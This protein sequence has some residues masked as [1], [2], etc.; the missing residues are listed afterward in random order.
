MKIEVKPN[1]RIVPG[2]ALILAAAV[3]ALPVQAADGLQWFRGQLHAHSYWSDGRAFPEQAIDAYKQRGYHFLCLT[4]HNR[5]PEDTGYWCKVTNEDGGWPPKV[6][7]E[8]FDSYVQSFGEDWVETRTDGPDT[9]VRLKTYAETKARFEE[10]GNF[11]L[12]PGVEITQTLNGVAVHQ[13]YI[14]LPL[15]VPCI[16]GA[17]LVLTLEGDRTAADLIRLNAIEA[18]Q[19]AA[20][21]QAPYLF[22]LN[23]PFWVYYDIVPQNLIDCPE[24]RFFEVCNGGSEF[25][26]HPQAQSYTV[27]KFWDAVNAFRRIQGQDLL[28]GVGSDDAHFYDPQRIDGNGGVGDAWVMVRAEALTP[29]HLLAAMQRGDF[30]ASTGVLLEDV[31]FTAADKTL[32]VKVK[33]E[34]GTAYR[35]YFITTKQG[36]DQAVTEIASPAEGDR[37]ARTVPV[38]SED[39]G[40]VVKTVDGTEAEYTLEADDLYVRACIESNRPGKYTRHFYPKVQTAWTQPCASE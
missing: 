13:N 36:F 8:M 39:I 26:P 1:L 16:T 5:F 31:A 35:I 38:Y 22:M 32:R 28:Y 33:P 18:R 20:E 7:H 3:A 14:N 6:S 9:Y 37:P 19:A 27:G 40:R 11:L 15:I 24:I 12:M 23:H 17:D 4:D 30:Y 10:P 34:E 29:E 21:R 2:I 25:A